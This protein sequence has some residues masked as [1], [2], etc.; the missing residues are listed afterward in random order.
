MDE[1]PATL[2]AALVALRQRAKLNQ[3]QLAAACAG[4]GVRGINQGSISR[5]EKG[6]L[7]PSSAQVRELHRACSGTPEDLAELLSLLVGVPVRLETSAEAT[8]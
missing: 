8:S 4:S 6:A 7:E 2:A 3:P 5:W 1:R